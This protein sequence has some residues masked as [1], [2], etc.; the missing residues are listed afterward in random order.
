MFFCFKL[1]R[2]MVGV[3]RTL[4]TRLAVSSPSPCR[5]HEIM[6][7]GGMLQMS[8]NFGLVIYI[9]KR[10][11]GLPPFPQVVAVRS[12]SILEAPGTM[13]S[14]RSWKGK[15]QGKKG[16]TCFYMCIMKL[17]SICNSIVAA[18]WSRSNHEGETMKR[19]FRSQANPCQLQSSR[20][21]FRKYTLYI[22]D[23]PCM[24]Y[25]P[26]LT[27]QTTPTDRHIWQSHGASGVYF[28]DF[29]I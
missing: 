21:S 14:Q 10:R 28:P 20:H 2:E 6:S 9:C 4:C 18:S 24:P 5:I 22:P 26:T 7:N 17:F 16:I 3:A 8:G 27:P 19:T 11:S 1:K 29:N 23:T 15:N 25:M 13:S 12:A